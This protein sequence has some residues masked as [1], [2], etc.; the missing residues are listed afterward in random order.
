MFKNEKAAYL[1]KGKAALNLF[2][3]RKNFT[4]KV[5]AIEEFL[6]FAQDMLAGY[7]LLQ[8]FAG[9]VSCSI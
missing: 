1:G 2:L 4:R 9:V 6:C 7:A 3:V 5:L 8:F